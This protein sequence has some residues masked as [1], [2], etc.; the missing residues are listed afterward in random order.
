MIGDIHPVQMGGVTRTPLR[1]GSIL[2]QGLGQIG[3]LVPK[4]GIPATGCSVLP[5]GIMMAII[6]L[7]V[8]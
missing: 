4:R 8:D 6:F 2:R 3:I 1:S 7:Q 5:T